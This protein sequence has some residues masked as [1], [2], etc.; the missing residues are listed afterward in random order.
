[1]VFVRLFVSISA[2]GRREGAKQT[3]N[4]DQSLHAVR[5]C[6]LV[7]RGPP[8]SSEIGRRRADPNERRCFGRKAA[9]RF[10]VCAARSPES[11]GG[12]SEKRIG[13]PIRL[14]GNAPSQGWPR[15]RKLLLCMESGV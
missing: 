1:K 2:R 6:T 14:K 5:P 8:H 10:S 13:P 4:D 7:I 3:E 15:P 9:L 11:W 12:G